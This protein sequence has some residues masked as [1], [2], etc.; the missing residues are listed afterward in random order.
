MATLRLAAAQQIRELSAPLLDRNQDVILTGGKFLCL[1]S[2]GHIARQIRIDNRP[3]RGYFLLEW[4]LT[5][6][7]IRGDKFGFG[8]YGRSIGLIGR[9]RR[10][11]PAGQDGVWDWDDPM[12]RDDFVEQIETEVLPFLRSLDS[13]EKIV[14]FILSQE[15][16]GYSFRKDHIWMCF[17]HAALGELATARTHWDLITP[18]FKERHENQ[19]AIDGKPMSDYFRSCLAVGEV[20]KGGDHMALAKLLWEN[21]RTEADRFKLGRHW[22]PTAFPFQKVAPPIAATPVDPTEGDGDRKGRAI[23]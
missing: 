4:R 8:G 13:I 15:I 9:S 10:F 1:Q 14:T 11:K 16:R 19:A 20:L 12:I 21:E 3:N 22:Q 18:S 23:A 2:V 17:T 6:L 7:Y 5:E